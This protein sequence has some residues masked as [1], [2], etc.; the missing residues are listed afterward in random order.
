M[1][2]TRAALLP[3]CLFV[4]HLLVGAESKIGHPT[5]LSPHV[6][7]IAVHE[8]LVFAVNTPADTL[9]ILD[10]TT[11]Q[12]RER[13]AVGVDP[14]SVAVRP[15]GSEIWVSN[16]ISDSVSVIDN[17]PE[18]RTYHAVIATIQ[19]LDLVR[20]AT[21]FNEPVDIAF[22]GN[23]KAYVALSSS[24]E[25]AVIDVAL[26]RV[27]KRLKIPAQEPRALSVKD[28]MLYVIPFESNN[29]TQLSGGEEGKI[30]GKLVTFD[31]K[32][33][34][35]AFDSA[36]FVVDLV[37]NPEI[38]DRDLFV[39][40]TKTDDL[41]RSVDSL[42]TLL[43][44][45]DVDSEGN[46]FIAHT[47][48][49]NHVNG[50]AGTKKHALRQ[51]ENRPYLNRVAKASADGTSTSFALNPLPPKQ[52]ERSKAIATPFAVKASDDNRVLYVT[53]AGSD[54]LVTVDAESG[55]VLGRA[56][57]ESV[58]RGVALQDAGDGERR[59]AWVLNAVSNSVSKV[60]VSVPE[61]PTVLATVPLVDPT[62]AIYKAGRKAFNTARASSNGTFACASCHADGHT[63]QLLWVLDTPHLVG[64]DQVEP[65]L[66]QTLRGLRGTAPYHWDGVPGDP[67][68]GTNAAT[69][70]RLP[71]NSEI[72]KPESAVRHVIDGSMASTMLAP[73]SEI[74]NDEGKKGY[75]S[76]EERDAMA[77]FLLNLSHMPTPGRAYTDQLSE[78]AR[79][80]F[81]RFHVTGA[82]DHKNLN[83]SVCGSCHTFPYLATDQDSM[84][85]PSFRGALDRFITQA[86]GRNSVISLGG[87]KQVAEKGWPE[88]EVWRRMLNMGE[89]RRL[90]PVLDMFKESSMGFSGAFGRQVT[91]S[92][93]TAVD[94]VTLD[95]IRALERASKEGGV[96]LQVT[97]RLE[98]KPFHAIYRDGNYQAQVGRKSWGRELLLNLAAKGDLVATFTG[99]HGADVISPPPAI[100][101]A[102]VLHKQRGQ[103]LFPR[104]NA[105]KRSMII[106]A[107][108]LQQGATLLVDGEQVDGTITEAG[109]ELVEVKLTSLPEK[110]MR[111]LQVQ[112]PD[113]Y[114]SNEFIFFVETRA[115]ALARYRKEP[116]VHL[117]TVLNSAL[118]NDHPEEANIAIEA[119]ADLNMP[120]EHFNFERPPL[121]IAAQYGHSEVVSELLK[122]G[123]DP[124]IQ[125]KTGDSALHRA[126]HMGRLGIVRKLLAAGA[127]P[128]LTNKRGKRPADLLRHFTKKRNFEK[129]HA[130]FN[131]NLTLDHDRYLRET[132]QVQALLTK[133]VTEVK[134]PNV[135]VLL[136]DDLGLRD[137][138][139]YGGPV[140]TPALD[141]LAAG[142][143]RF[144]N[145]Y[146]GASVCSPSRAT[147]LTG[148][149]HLRTGVYTVVQDHVH[150]MHLLEREVTIAEVLKKNGYQT[151]H[152][153][154]WHVGAPFRGKKKPSLDDHGFDHW[155]AT[156]NNA[157]PSHRDPVNFYR[158]GKRVGKIEGYASHILADE[159]IGWLDKERKKDQPFFLNIWF[160]EPH[161]PLAAPAE[162]VA[163]YGD[164]KDEAALYSATVDNT[165]RAI[166][167]LLAKLKAMGELE[168]TLIVYASDHGSYRPDRNGGYRG[169]KGSLFEG[170]LRTPGIFHWPEGI[171]GGRVEQTPGASVDLL[172]TICGLLRISKP[173]G[174][175]LDGSDLSPLLR[176][177]GTFRRHQPLFWHSPM[178]QP[179]VAMRDG[180]FV[181]FGYRAHE[182]RRD[183]KRMNELLAQLG[184]AWEKELGRKLERGELYSKS[185]NGSLKDPT[186][187]KVR[188]EFVKQLMFQEAWTPIIKAGSGGFRHFELY[189]VR[190]DPGQ[191]VN[192][193]SRRPELAARLKEQMLK[194]NSHVL[195]DAPVWGG[196]QKP[197]P[198]GKEAIERLLTRIDQ[199]DLPKGYHGLTHQKY[200]DK[201]MKEIGGEKRSRV[202]KL[203][204]EK[205]RLH[206]NMKNRG[207]SFVRILEFVAGE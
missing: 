46:V 193:F 27:V 183:Q 150:E 23:K 33:L 181:L 179:N 97:G 162:I 92:R 10:A 101:T 8:G 93:G 114:L 166:A 197:L 113:S 170:G 56:K 30:D 28:G 103:Q 100:W 127:D 17:D 88:E 138:G 19:D 118:I 153:G 102:G 99:R 107:L 65:R 121:I 151:V 38:P 109:Q 108:Y 71:P 158:N 163:K 31:A 5:L 78:K 173:Q 61:R 186:A 182:F 77:I 87:V 72:N 15:D 6:D 66:S 172:P 68:G 144:L 204:R 85:V 154:K 160:H 59:L 89:P 171:A 80:G 111:L 7:P 180:D 152:L 26:R 64:A 206:P 165:D 190:A 169:E 185:A 178:A 1:I 133:A 192:L 9:D 136:A 120:H 62:P 95:L 4:S 199:N 145:F 167:R 67:Y 13:V 112:N 117:T 131:V 122:R 42:G 3:L 139:S 194:I 83:T 110:G 24:N 123:A 141:S 130:P 53:A 76:K 55:R 164:L 35:G 189:D 116:A 134:R 187:E 149:Q 49:R 128:L 50:R 29:Q 156:D 161:S 44:G 25:V 74:E 135:I 137:I 147:L 81:E 79:T 207:A 195:A 176:E 155:F 177:R 54:H 39:F 115:E 125:T 96:V 196:K 126:A 52:P 70:D 37:K 168:N 205:E 98:R 60:D 143:V 157:A 84:N 73:G 146:A 69:R 159:A 188:G 175:H 104:I 36:G 90:W 191:R 18:S 132:P 48:A 94:P 63:D 21:R 75:L 47:E 40:E 105:K 106:S 82:R 198:P 11:N 22:A 20:K 2:L 14:V 142:G 32:K 58:P 200:V 201:K 57:V 43:F 129:H 119:G 16:H 12:V 51:L 45:L 86:Q 148:R 184:T 202:G 41:V 91:L 140:N 34:A 203:W 124:N 174:V